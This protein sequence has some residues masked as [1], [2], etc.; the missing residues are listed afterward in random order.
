MVIGFFLDT[1]LAPTTSKME[2]IHQSVDIIVQMMDI[3]PTTTIEMIDWSSHFHQPSRPIY[4]VPK[5]HLSK[6]RDYFVDKDWRLLPTRTN[7]NVMHLCPRMEYEQQIDEYLTTA[8]N[9]TIIEQYSNEA[10]FDVVVDRI[11]HTL[12]KL[13]RKRKLS[14][15]HYWTMGYFCQDEKKIFDEI[16]FVPH[17]NNPLEPIIIF[18]KSPTKNIVDYLYKIINERYR[19]LFRSSTDECNAAIDLI[20]EFEAY[21][22]NGFLK[23]TTLVAC[24]ELQD[25][26]RYLSH[27]GM[28][29]A[30]QRFLDD[31]MIDEDT[32]GLSHNTIICLADMVL[33]SQFYRHG[34]RIYRKTRGGCQQVPFFRLLTNIYLVYLQND[35]YDIFDAYDEIFYRY[36]SCHMRYLTRFVLIF[37]LDITIRS[38]VHG[39]HR[40]LFYVPYLDYIWIFVVICPL[41]SPSVHR[42]KQ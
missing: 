18:E 26:D 25:L 38:S 22:A 39:M 13:Q 1:I 41:K 11:Q 21:S 3:D 24:V 34:H 6:V 7:M 14:D 8:D 30:L 2:S 29:D 15:Q 27:G 5:C 42:F 10:L 28:I 19:L 32:H 17:L 4:A 37:F 12:M 31:Y 36:V 35:L 23:D 9:F 40:R 20:K 33:R 16:F